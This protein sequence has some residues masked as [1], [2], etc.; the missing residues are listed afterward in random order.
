MKN[1]LVTG[2]KGFI[3]TYIVDHFKDKYN[4]STIEDEDICSQNL[5]PYFRHID[6]VIHLAAISGIDYCDENPELANR[7]NFFGTENIL[8]YA[9]DR[10]VRKVIFISSSSV[11]HSKGIY[12]K[13]K[14][15]AEKMCKYYSDNLGLQTVILRLCN[16]YDLNKG[17]GVVD[18][19]YDSNKLGMPLNIYGSGED[20]YDFIHVLDIVDLIEKIVEQDGDHYADI[21]DVGTGNKY[22]INEIAKVMSDNI[23]HHNKKIIYKPISPD[24]VSTQEA[25]DW[26]PQRDLLA[27]LKTI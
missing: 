21:F 18:K 3:G 24:I 6:Y 12:A 15:N 13:T 5:K 22:S 4:I 11:Y 16:V 2:A 9:H 26:K 20:S 8:S 27:L 14:K 23:I 25:F 1:I 10:G 19:F 17:Y 7:V